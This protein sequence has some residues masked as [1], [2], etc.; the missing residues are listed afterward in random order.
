VYRE[1]EREREKREKERERE[2]ERERE[3]ERERARYIPFSTRLLPNCTPMPANI[4]SR[5]RF[6]VTNSRKLVPQ[7]MYHINPPS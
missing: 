6:S 4:V 1:R 3:K 7:Y 2:R 5:F